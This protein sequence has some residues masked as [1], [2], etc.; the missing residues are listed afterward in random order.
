MYVYMYY[1]IYI[2]IYMY[3]YVQVYVLIYTRRM[4]VV[5]MSRIIYRRGP[6]FAHQPAQSTGTICPHG[7]FHK[8]GKSK[9]MV[10]SGNAETPLE[11]NALGVPHVRKPP[12]L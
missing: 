11:I 12:H 4:A 2:Y 7:G 9:W 1:T 5:N 10:C 3:T 6:L 8:C